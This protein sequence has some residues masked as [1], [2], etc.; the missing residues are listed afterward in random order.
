MPF[1]IADTEIQKT[2]AKLGIK[3]PE[4]FRREMMTSNGGEILTD[5]DAWTQYPILDTSDRKRLSRTCNDIVK[6]TAS[7]KEWDGFPANG[8]AIA[9]NECGDQLLLLPSEGN[10]EVLGE[11]IYTFRHED[12]QVERL[13]QS[14]S[15]FRSEYNAN[16]PMDLTPGNAALS[17]ASTAAATRSGTEAAKTKSSLCAF[18]PAA[19]LAA[20]IPPVASHRGR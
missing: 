18:T 8:V 10:N 9:R 4:T 17:V 11:T 20:S 2:E 19:S 12:G 1:P 14:I 15:E 13:A 3:F 6:E 5:D 7:A 16:R